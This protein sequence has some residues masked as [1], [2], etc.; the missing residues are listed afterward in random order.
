M[1]HC[2][3]SHLI[4]E[5]CQL[6]GAVFQAALQMCPLGGHGR[7]AAAVAH[8]LRGRLLKCLLRMP[9]PGSQAAQRLLHSWV[10][11]PALSGGLQLVHAL[12]AGCHRIL[13]AIA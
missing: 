5:A 13:H 9:E 12:T 11:V 7:D 3:A 4:T 8:L 1:C 6:A 2:W 10:A